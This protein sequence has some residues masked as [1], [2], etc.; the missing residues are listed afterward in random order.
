MLLGQADTA[1]FIIRPDDAFQLAPQGASQFWGAVLPVSDGTVMR[2]PSYLLCHPAFSGRSSLAPPPPLNAERLKLTPAQQ[3]AR[4]LATLWTYDS[5]TARGGGVVIAGLDTT[6]GRALAVQVKLVAAQQRC[7][8]AQRCTA[9]CVHC[10]VQAL[11]ATCSG[12]DTAVFAFSRL[13]LLL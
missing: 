2:A 5:L 10:C 8:L 11:H 12:S 7:G 3:Y 9:A 6:I 13:L 4:K 1:G